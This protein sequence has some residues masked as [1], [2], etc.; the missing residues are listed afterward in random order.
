[1][2]FLWFSYVLLIEDVQISQFPQPF[3]DCH[4][5]MT[6]MEKNPHFLVLYGSSNIYWD[7]SW[8]LIGIYI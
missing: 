8:E 6:G 7:F 2:V 1:M 3:D 4:D 5:G